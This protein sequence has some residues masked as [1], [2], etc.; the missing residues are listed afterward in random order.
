MALT[1]AVV[2]AWYALLRRR[3]GP[4]ALA[5]GGLGWLAVLGVA[6]AAFAPGGSYLTAVPA[7]AGA[8][9]GIAAVFLRGWWSVLSVTLGAAVAVVVLLPMMI[10]FFPALGLAGPG[11]FV[12]TLLGLATLPVIDLLHP[13][14][15]GQRGL[16]AARAR[17][18][19]AVPTLAAALAVLACTVTGLAVDR[20]DAAHPAPTHLLYALDTDTNEARWLSADNLPQD[21]TAQYVSGSAAAVT[22][23]LPAFGD[24]KL[25]SGPAQ[26]VT[27]PAPQL[28]KVDDSTAGGLRTIRL[29]LTPQRPV[30]LVTLHVGAESAVTEA[31]VGGR[32]VPTDRTAGGPWGF[33][34]VFHAPPAGGVE[35]T[36]TVRGTGPLKLRVMDGSDGISTLPGFKPRPADVGVTGSHSSEMLAVARTYRL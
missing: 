23:G 13:E 36:M 6:L 15:G 8:L 3:L 22:E 25:F 21:W 26:A 18:L 10:M 32:S 1:A 27:L 24:E 16:V 28:T 30:R 31:T 11:A 5:I 7:L 35:I 34:F 20:F 2:F 9:A 12:A 19:G 17:R 33:G 4:A 14:A 29:R